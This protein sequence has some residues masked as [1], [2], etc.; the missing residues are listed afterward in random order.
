MS[1]L[2]ATI[3]TA[4]ATA[5]LA[6]FAV[7]TAVLAWLAFRKQPQEV[8]ILLEQSNREAGERRRAQAAQVYLAVEDLPFEGDP[9]DMRSAARLRNESALPVYDI[10]L[11]LAESAD[12]HRQVLLPG[13]ELT[14]PGL[15]T[16]FADGRRPVWAAFRDSAGIRWRI[17]AYGQLAELPG[18]APV[19]GRVT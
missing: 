10:M 18:D 14:R 19:P 16:A 9:A 2:G 4:V 8:G 6:V 7:V 11:G 15:G 12:Q 3:L 5:V 17:T 1:L 13:K